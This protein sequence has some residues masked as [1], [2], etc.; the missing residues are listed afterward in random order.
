MAFALAF[1]VLCPVVGALTAWRWWL[2]HLEAERLTRT[3]NIEA[4]LAKVAECEKKLVELNEKL[5][6]QERATRNLEI[7]TSGRG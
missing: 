1:C 4:E 7:R 2:R 3:R 6:L 5:L